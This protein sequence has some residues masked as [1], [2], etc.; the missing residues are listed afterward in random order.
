MSEF[1]QLRALDLTGG[2]GVY[3]TGTALVGL[4]GTPAASTAWPAANQAI[5]VPMRLAVPV[6]VYK[7]AMGAGLTAAGNF[8]I[9]IY[10]ATGK[11]LVHS[12]ATAK[13]STVE[14]VIDITDTRLG[15][16]LYYLAL[17]ADGTNNYVMVTPSGSSPVPLQKARLWGTLQMA[18]AYTLPDPA[19]FAA[20]DA[21]VIPAIAA[22]LRPY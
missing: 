9:G 4:S 2:G 7:M 17:A 5:F 1:P 15:P 3:S 19:T 6:I 12:G 20:R 11:R 8:D 18:T 16:G 14:Q 10:D 21:A 22:Y 13:L